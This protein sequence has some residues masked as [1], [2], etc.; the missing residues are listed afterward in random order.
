MRALPLR[1]RPS[2]GRSGLA[3]DQD[4][5]TPDHPH[6][7]LLPRRFSGRFSTAHDHAGRSASSVSLAAAPSRANDPTSEEV[8]PDLVCR[9]A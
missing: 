6:S 9:K 4:A 7:V 1:R 3:E 5:S 2:R 8:Y